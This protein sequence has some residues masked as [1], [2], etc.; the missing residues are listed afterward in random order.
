VRR[1]VTFPCPKRLGF[2]TLPVKDEFIKLSRKP[3]FM[4]NPGQSFAIGCVRFANQAFRRLILGAVNSNH[5]LL[6]YE[7]GGYAHQYL[8]GVL[9]GVFE[10]N[11]KTC[12]LIWKGTPGFAAA[13]KVKTFGELKQILNSGKT[14]ETPY[15]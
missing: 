3:T 10:L 8:V 13:A 6:F 12:R 4:A 1:G 5:C 9:V 14:S 15:L 11:A 7:K 2:T